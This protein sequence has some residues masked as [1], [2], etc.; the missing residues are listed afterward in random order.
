MI[1]SEK[2]KSG[3]EIVNDFVNGLK[4]DSS[5]DEGVVDSLL[6]IMKGGKPTQTRLLQELEIERKKGAAND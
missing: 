1:G 4:A 2:I 6:Q 5:L 3:T